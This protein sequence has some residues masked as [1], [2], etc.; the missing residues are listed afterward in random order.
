MAALAEGLIDVHT[1]VCPLSFPG[2]PSPTVTQ[3]PCMCARSPTEA[4]IE[5]GGKTFRELDDRSWSAAR[6]IEDM[7]RD[8]VAVQ[9][10]SPMPEL[11][12][13]WFDG[14]AAELMAE[15]MNGTIAAMI[16]HDPRRFRGLGML[17]MQ[18]VPRAV[19]GLERLRERFGLDGI[20]IGSHVDRVMLGDRRFDPV[21]EAA[22]S[23]GL[24]VLIHPLHPLTARLEGVSPLLHPLVGFLNEGAIA[25]GSLLMAGVLDRYPRLRIGLTHGGGGLA[26]VIARLDQAWHTMPPFRGMLERLPSEQ[27]RSLFFDTNVYDSNYVAYLARVVAPGRLFVGT[28]YPYQIM[29]AD[30]AA[31][32][33][34][35]NLSAAERASVSEGAARHFLGVTG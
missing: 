22:E 31:Y 16:A 30:P 35:A 24:A 20:E 9:V 32:V 18:D 5:I 8:G 27:A 29:Q 28:D 10:L 1:H 7:D 11:L 34:A 25:G 17:P 14:A 2:S 12:S 6:R 4:A 21:W 26:P 23:L 19:R 13:Y 33:A 3:W 15:H